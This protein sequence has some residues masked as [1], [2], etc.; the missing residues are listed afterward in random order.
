[1]QGVG[2]GLGDMWK[3]GQALGSLAMDCAQGGAAECGSR[4]EKLGSYVVNHPGDFFGSLVGYKDLSQ[5]NYA[6]W[7]GHLAPSI[8][9][10]DRDRGWR[11]SAGQGR[12]SGRTR[13]RRRG[14]CRRS[15]WHGCWRSSGRSGRRCGGGRCRQGSPGI[16]R[17]DRRK[18]QRFRVSVHR[19][20]GQSRYRVIRHNS[21]GR[22][23]QVLVLAYPIHQPVGCTERACYAENPH[24]R[25]GS[26]ERADP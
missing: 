18:C 5:G 9:I 6:K 13:R 1:M 20:C 26:A 14:G 15:R 21:P 19:R 4:L 11:G 10:D 16:G 2:D 23:R 24:V 22:Q 25:Y 3:G 8:R 17:K 7:A 12:R